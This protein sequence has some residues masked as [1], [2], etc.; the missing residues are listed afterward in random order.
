MAGPLSPR[1]VKRKCSVNF[2]PPLSACTVHGAEMPLSARQNSSSAPPKV[3]GT[4]PAR[5]GI[6]RSPNCP[7]IRYAKSLAPNFGSDRPPVAITSRGA[8]SVSSCVSTTKP[9]PSST[10]RTDFTSAPVRIHHVRVGAFVQQH[11]RDL[12]RAV[13]AEKLPQLLLVPANAVAL[14]K[15]QE[16]LRRVAGQGR[17]AEIRVRR[18]IILR[19]RAQVGEIAAPAAGDENLRAHPSAPLQHEHRPPAPGPAIIAHIS[20]AAPAPIT[21]TSLIMRFQNRPLSK[22][23]ENNARQKLIGWPQNDDILMVELLE[24]RTN[25]SAWAF[26]EYFILKPDGEQTGTYSLEQVRSMLNSGFIGTDARYWHEGIADWQPIDQIEESINFPEPDPHQLHAPP[27]PRKWTGSLARAIPSPNQKRK[28][29]PI[30]VTPD[31]AAPPT[32]V[33]PEPIRPVVEIPTPTVRVETL[34]STNG[35]T[36]HQAAPSEPA[37]TRAQAAA[38]APRTEPRRPF[39]LPLPAPHKFA[40]SG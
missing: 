37:F 29:G 8:N 5:G 25:L 12:A 31:A 19:P 28:S 36:A 39:R 24:E 14:H 27:P 18:E 30:D 9:P 1:C 23:M 7:A 22:K 4:N 15:R 11:V 13:V 6:M 10:R 40:P 26:M 38:E 34:P 32:P 35:A 33:V 2:G 17:L 21:I 3:N 20:P 16:I